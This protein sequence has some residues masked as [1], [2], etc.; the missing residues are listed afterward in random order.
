M[1][2]TEI[3]GI[4]IIFLKLQ[5]QRKLFRKEWKYYSPHLL[6]Q[7]LT[8]SLKNFS[9]KTLNFHIYKY[10]HRKFCYWH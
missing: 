9:G 8:T 2:K 7:G 6:L 10:K 5:M 3:L 1:R 4:A